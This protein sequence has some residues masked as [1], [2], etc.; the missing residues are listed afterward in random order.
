[1]PFR[2]VRSTS[3]VGKAT[4]ELQRFL[5]KEASIVDLISECNVDAAPDHFSKRHPAISS[6]GAKFAQLLL[7]QLDL[8]SYH[9]LSVITS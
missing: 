4:D 1:M 8:C 9:I 3:L 5:I 7:R 6:P 2:K